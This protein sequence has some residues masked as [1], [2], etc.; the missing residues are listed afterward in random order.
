MQTFDSH[1]PLAC[2][3]APRSKIRWVFKT[4]GAHSTVYYLKDLVKVTQY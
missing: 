1:Y 2:F 3:M 4:G